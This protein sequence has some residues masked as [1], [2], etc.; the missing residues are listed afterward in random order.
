MKIET[1][2]QL[3]DALEELNKLSTGENA[4]CL[5]AEIDTAIEL[6]REAIATS[7]NSNVKKKRKDIHMQKQLRRF[8]IESIG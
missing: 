6:L 1:M 5:P 3:L 8:I 4:I 2:K 7:K